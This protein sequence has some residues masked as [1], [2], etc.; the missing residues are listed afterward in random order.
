MATS[1]L[2]ANRATEAGANLYLG[3]G[4]TT[5]YVL[6]APPGYYVPAATKCEVWREACPSEY[7]ACEDAAEGCKVNLVDNVNN[8]VAS[9][10]S[11]CQPTTFNQ[12]CDWR[13]NSDPLGKTV[14]VL[15]LG[16]HD[17]DYPFACAPGVLGGNG[18]L[19]SQ[20]TSAAC[21]GLCPAGF[22]CGAEATVAPA[23]CPRGSYC[24]E[25]TSVALS[26]LPGSYSIS[27]NLTNRN[28]CTPTDA[29]HFAPTGST[30]QIECSPG[31]VAPNASMG[32]CTKCAAGTF[33]ATPGQLACRSCTPGSY[34][35]EGAA[36]ALPCKAGTYQNETML[37]LNLSMTG[38]NDCLECPPGSAC[39]TGAAEP[40]KC[41]PG[42]VAPNASM[43]TCIKCAAGTYQAGEGEQACVACEP[44][45]YCPEGASAPLP[46]KEGSHSDATNLTSPSECTES[47][48]GHFSPT[49]STEQ[50][51]CS[52]GTVQPMAR[53][54]TCVPCAAGSFMNVRGQSVCLECP[55]GSAC[56]AQATAA[57]PCP[58]GT[59]GGSS[60]LRGFSDCEDAPP[61]FYAQAGSVAPTPCPSWGFCP[62]R[63]ADQVN[64]V[65]GGIPIVIPEG[66][67][68]TTVTKVVE[69]AI[70]QTVLELPLQVEV[71]DV[72]AFNDTAVRLRVADMLGLPLHAVSLSF[73]ASR[74]RLDLHA[75]RLRRLVALDF[76]VTITDEPA[77]NITSAASVWKSKSR[78][79]LSADLGLDVTDALSPVIATEVTVRYVTVSTLVIVECPAGSWGANGE[80]VKCSKGTYRPGGANGTGCVE[81]P[82]GTYQPKKGG[83]ECTVCGVGSYSANSLSCEP[84]QKGTYSS[85]NAAV[86]CLECPSGKYQPEAGKISCESCGAGSY[87]ANVLSC[88]PC[89]IGEYCPE[90]SVVGIPCPLGS[91]TEG[92]GAVNYDDC[93]CPAGTFDTTAA[94]D[95]ISCKPCDDDHMLCAR[96]GLT[97]ATVPL[98]PSRWRLSVTDR[99]IEPVGL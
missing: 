33:Q 40:S 85:G 20:Q 94:E 41:S 22:T 92:N 86:E 61:G 13:S 21:A 17:L 72:D 80:C 32:A 63:L 66:Q 16:P 77:V 45:S 7:S 71:A 5:T 53:R 62:G 88:E 26:C 55:A 99:Y 67:Q 36:A 25:G 38:A 56:A 96:T 89:Q 12:P 69:Q 18:S 2:V 95:E 31:T 75:A 87:S 29:G 19:T 54:G 51:K 10:S 93:G 78:S 1:R 39:G 14:Y 65:P 44:G 50:T 49:G 81:C 42:T 64:D 76:V 82:P 60:G 98:P 34:C 37:Q 11:S 52:P 35:A 48:A 6:P 79:T 3:A 58:G 8:C 27:N 30:E 46:C 83:T 70:N 97:L 74:R 90:G 91:T 15:P 28:D 9:S 43:A 68:T 59:F 73:A 23:V 57:V 4:S 24:P 47:E 84:C